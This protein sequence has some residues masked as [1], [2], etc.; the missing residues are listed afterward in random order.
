MENFTMAKDNFV[1]MKAEE[2]TQLQL[3]RLQSTFNRACRNVPF[4]RERFTAMGIDVSQV[5]TIED[6]V[7]LEFMERKHFSENYPYNLFAVPLRDIVRIHTSPGTGHHL[8]VSGYT[9]QDLKTWESI[10][11]RGLAAAE[12]TPHDILQICFHQGLSNWGRDYKQGAEALEAG[13]IPNTQL[14]VEKQLMV[15]RDYKTSALVTTPA[16]AHH[17]SAHI[18]ENTV[19]INTLALKTL[20][21][22]GEAMAASDRQQLEEN[23]H[24]TTWQHYGLSEI[25]GPAIAFECEH[26]AGLHIN[27][28]HFFPEIIDPT[29]GRVLD[30]GAF[31]ELVLTTLTTRAFPLIRFRTGD[32]ARIIPDPCPC[33]RRLMRMEWHG[34]RTDGLIPIDG[35]NLNRRRIHEL[36]QQNVDIAAESAELSV[37]EKDGKKYLEIRI[38][39][40]DA[41]F[42]DEIKG[43]ER[44]IGRT[45][46]RLEDDLCVPVV[47]HLKEKK[48]LGPHL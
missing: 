18:L 19:N 46:D 24:V 41:L 27:E 14:S 2:Q 38:P 10:L 11:Y 17:L 15:L 26:H 6:I 45:V 39:L 8:T 25:P 4:H 23:L 1:Q 12:V 9:A 30:R 48:Y 5:Q 40:N 35:I 36:L 28:D 3:E 44:L 33:G 13:V 31:G 42:S 32:R 7:L 16:A 47:I 43:L 20:V 34:E 37:S 21:L 29:T 22:A